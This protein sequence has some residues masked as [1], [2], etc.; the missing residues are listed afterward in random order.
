MTVG[1]QIL[2][3]NI[4]FSATGAAFR[5]FGY[6]FAGMKTLVIHPAD[7][8]TDFLCP[9]Y[10]PVKNKTVIT[11]GITKEHL[12]KYIRDHDRIQIMGHGETQTKINNEIIFLMVVGF[13]FGISKGTIF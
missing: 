7:R 9:I 4:S 13:W 6:I 8:S 2:P 11:G 12:R 3:Q 10:E 1:G 5:I